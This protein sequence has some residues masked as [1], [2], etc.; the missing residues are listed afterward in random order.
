MKYKHFKQTLLFKVG[1]VINKI[2]AITEHKLGTI[3]SIVK[4][5]KSV[6]ID[7]ESKSNI[8]I[9]NIINNE[10]ISRIVL[11]TFNIAMNNFFFIVYLIP[12]F[13]NTII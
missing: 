8:D 11:I 5:Q 6:N 1:S 10:Y 2:N 4:D 13:R 9:N 3:L 7:K 12:Y